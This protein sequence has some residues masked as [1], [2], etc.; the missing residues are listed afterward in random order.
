MVLRFPENFQFGTST[1][2]YQ[3]ETAVNH[4]W[5]GVKS[6]DGFIFEKTTDHEK[7]YDEDIDIIASLAPNYRMSLMWSRLQ[8][9][10][11]GA[12]DENVKAEYHQ[13]LKSLRSKNVSIMMVLHHF[14]NP[15]WFKAAGGW[16]KEKNITLW[17]DYAC[18]LIDEFGDYVSIWNTFNEPNLYATLSFGLGEFPPYKTSIVAAYKVV[19]NISKAHD[20][21][22]AYLK[23]KHP[24]KLVGISHNSA[25][26]AAHNLLGYLPA[27]LADLWYMEFIPRF[28]L[29]SDYIGMSYYARI[30]Y[31]PLP[32]SQLYTPEKM[33]RTGKDHDDIWEYYPEGLRINI[34]RYA[35]YKKPIIIT[36]NGICTGDDSKRV[37]AIKDYSK[38]IYE[39]LQEGI[40]IKAYYHWSS[41]DNFEWTLGPTFK[42]GLYGCDPHT[43][44]RSKKP[45]ADVFSE[46]AHQRVIVL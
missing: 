32:I 43:M 40:D 37:K 28:F 16:E 31:D 34:H 13:L 22:Y 39:C 4:D 7:R 24:E 29:N 5:C 21:I 18:K 46:L 6:Q 44:E 27:K 45:S 8:T 35:K 14:A 11:M 3:I 19:D 36:E 42:F 25:I 41:W 23:Q 9:V 33:K 26:F 10:P 38:I 2:A 12:L 17:F 15:A 30:P 1:S 20:M